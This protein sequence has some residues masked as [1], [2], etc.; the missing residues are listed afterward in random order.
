M[1]LTS[2]VSPRASAAAAAL[3]ASLACSAP[4][5]AVP[6]APILYQWPEPAFDPSLQCRGNYAVP[7]LERYLPHARLALWLPGTVGVELDTSRRCIRVAVEDVNTGRQ[8][9]LILRGTAVPRQAVLLEL[10]AP[11]APRGG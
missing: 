7:E 11:G 2:A 6:P 10:S 8:V 9:D 4:R 1:L 3:A 5:P